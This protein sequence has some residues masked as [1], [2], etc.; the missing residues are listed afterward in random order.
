MEKEQRAFDALRSKSSSCDSNAIVFTPNPSYEEYLKIHKVLVGPSTAKELERISINLSNETVPRYLS[1]AGWA[2]AEAALAQPDQNASYRN[3]LLEQSSDCWTRALEMQLDW[4][5]LGLEY[6]TE[7]TA[8]YRYA[9][10]LAHLPIL[11]A[12]ISGDVTPKTRSQVAIDVLNIAE[13]NIIQMHLAKALGNKDALGDHVGLG[14][15]C[16][17]LLAFHSLDSS[18]LFAI[19]SSARADSGHHH[20]NQTHDL[21]IIQQKWGTITDMTPA[22]IK[23]TISQRDR[24]RY[25]ALLVRGKMHLSIQGKHAPEY[26]LRAFSGLYNG[27]Q[28]PIERAI[29]NHARTTILDLYWLYKKGSKIDNFASRKSQCQYRNSDELYMSYPEIAPAI[30]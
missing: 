18:G 12:I 15:E 29:T 3:R 16:N 21:L 7:H 25:K 24:H 4:N 10:D 23:S 9:L 26:T 28:T 6:L 13:A 22:E 17:G 2:A 14:Y 19:P 5:E 8:P 30:M 11:Q 27:T 1:A 20:K